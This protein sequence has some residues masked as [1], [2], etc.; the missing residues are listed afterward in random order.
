MSHLPHPVSA[1]LLLEQRQAEFLAA[2]A[3]ER[4]AALAECRSAPSG[5]PRWP[6]FVATA[7]IAIARA[8]RT[9]VGAARRT[10]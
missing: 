6:V 3:R 1:S 7:W 9:A 2:S 10:A 4:R 8:R 5:R